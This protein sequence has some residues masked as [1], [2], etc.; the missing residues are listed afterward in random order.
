M[1]MTTQHVIVIC[2]LLINL[3]QN[4]ANCERMT[5]DYC[6]SFVT[7]LCKLTKSVTISTLQKSSW[8]QEAW[9][10]VL[11]PRQRF[12]T[13][14]KLYT[15]EE[16]LVY[17]KLRNVWIIP[18]LWFWVWGI[19]QLASRTKPNLNFTDNSRL[20]ILFIHIAFEAL[21]ITFIHLSSNIPTC[22]FFSPSVK[23][24]WK[25]IA[26]GL[27]CKNVWGTSPQNKF[28]FNWLPVMQCVLSGHFYC[29]CPMTS[30]HRWGCHW[31]L[32]SRCQNFYL[33]S[34]LPT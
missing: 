20:K 26:G 16:D 33:Q 11:S 1:Q 22:P 30:T 31:D 10:H 28:S 14:Q 15:T 7:Q 2:S 5:L 6:N 19:P 25:V 21:H 34:K 27:V 29:L 13:Q 12:L 32:C 23:L 9:F 17:L 4:S 3:F 8:A 18:A 24:A